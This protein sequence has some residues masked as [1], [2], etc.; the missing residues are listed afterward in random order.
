M[1]PIIKQG[2]YLLVPVNKDWDFVTAVA[3][4]TF[5]AMVDRTKFPDGSFEPV[6]LAKNLTK[7]QLTNIGVTL[8]DKQIEAT[9]ILKELI[10]TTNQ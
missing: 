5:A 1:T 4:L 9:L 7:K 2:E 8:S 6:N 3:R 10:K